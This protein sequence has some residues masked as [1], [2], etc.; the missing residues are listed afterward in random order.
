MVAGR[1]KPEL[2]RAHTLLTGS[3]F[4]L[5]CS[6]RIALIVHEPSTHRTGSA[7][8]F[9]TLVLQL[10]YSYATYERHMNCVALAP[11]VAGHTARHKKEVAAF[12]P[13][14]LPSREGGVSGG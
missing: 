10:R 6:F 8:K 2:K 1:R 7:S 13:P 5:T 3:Q 14:R 9:S 4:R 12:A 11:V